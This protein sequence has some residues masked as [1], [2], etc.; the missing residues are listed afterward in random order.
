MAAKHVSQRKHFIGR[1]LV[2]RDSKQSLTAIVGAAGSRRTIPAHRQFGY[3]GLRLAKGQVRDASSTVGF[4]N[5]DGSPLRMPWLQTRASMQGCSSTQV[6]RF[7]ADVSKPEH[8][9]ERYETRL[10]MPG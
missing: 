10:K 6:R 8:A 9:A 7:Y 2:G 4:A 3:E 1:V 5:L